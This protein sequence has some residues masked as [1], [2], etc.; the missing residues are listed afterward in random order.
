MKEVCIVNAHWS[1]RGDEAALRPIIDDIISNFQQIHI[2][3]IFKDKRDIQMFP[4]NSSEVS[5]FSAQFLPEDEEDYWE[6]YCEKRRMNPNM[7]KIVDVCRN[8]DVIIY[9]PGGAVLSDK[10]WWRKQLEYMLPIIVGYDNDIP[11]VFAAPSIG[12]F[13]NNTEHNLMRKKYFGKARQICVRESMSKKYLYEIGVNRNVITTVDTAF[14]D[15]PQIEYNKRLFSNDLELELFFSKHEK[16]VALTI[17]DFAWH[18]ELSNDHNLRTTIYKSMVDI[19]FDL[20]NN[21]GMGVILIPQLFGNQN[22]TTFLTEFSTDGTLI[23]SEKYD[24]YFQQYVISRCFGLIGMRYHSNIFAA[25][26]GIPFIAISYED[27]M[28][29]FLQDWSLCDLAI[30][31]DEFDFNLLNRK[32]RYLVENHAEIQKRLKSKRE[33]WRK[34]AGIT[35]QQIRDILIEEN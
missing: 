3:V 19:I 26:M 22:D 30:G 32:W 34:K 24:T 31:I 18:V 12:K 13:D 21:Q 17:T 4:Y 6:M 35:I 11:I 5:Y 25:K 9:S 2:T 15:D 28:S 33:I 7:K 23:L 1:N 10:F 8:A 20:V 29:G 27:K 14:F 16:V